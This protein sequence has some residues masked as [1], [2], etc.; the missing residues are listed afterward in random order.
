MLQVWVLWIFFGLNT[1]SHKRLFDRSVSTNP[2]SLTK[3]RIYHANHLQLHQHH[4]RHHHHPEVVVW[5]G[6]LRL[7]PPPFRKIIA[8]SD[9]KLVNGKSC[10]YL[11]LF[12]PFCWCSRRSSNA[13]CANWSAID[14]PLE[15]TCHRHI[16]REPTTAHGTVNYKY[17]LI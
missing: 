16:H 12:A 17:L 13:G 4:L 3:S 8:Y 6:P 10:Q 15:P 7:T 2:H 1:A 11:F 9:D 5:S 14:G